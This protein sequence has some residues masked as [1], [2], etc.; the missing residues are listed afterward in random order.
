M[1]FIDAASIVQKG[2]SQSSSDDAAVLREWP[3]SATSDPTQVPLALG[4]LINWP[5][6]AISA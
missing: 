2:A 3:F 4:V 1:V 5:L 6:C